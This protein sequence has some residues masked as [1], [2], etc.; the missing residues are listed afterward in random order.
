MNGHPDR[1]PLRRPAL[2]GGAALGPRAVRGQLDHPGRLGSLAARSAAHPELGDDLGHLDR[3]PEQVDPAPAEAGQFPNAQAAVGGDQD[4]GAVA[5]LDAIGQAADPPSRWRPRSWVEPAVG[6]GD[7]D[8]G[9][10][11]SSQ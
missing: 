2:P 10:R 3:P 6:D 7:D 11:T 4:Q 5:R 8:Q 1:S 9:T